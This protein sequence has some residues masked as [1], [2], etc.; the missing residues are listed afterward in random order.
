M[1]QSPSQRILVVEDEPKMLSMITQFLE[2]EGW[3]VYGSATGEEA[4]KLMPKVAPDVV[5]LDWMLPGMSGLDVCRRIRAESQVPLIMLTAKADEVDKL[6]GLE[7]GADDYITK[8]FS[9]RELLARI[10]AVLRRSSAAWREER[11]GIGD[12]II[13][14]DK[15]EVRKAGVKVQ[16]TPTEFKILSILAS[17]PGRVYS[18]LQLVDA[19]LGQ[20]Y[21]GYERSIDTHISNLRKK[22]GDDSAQPRYIDT[23][24]GVGYKMLDARGGD[25]DDS[26]ER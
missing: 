25:A 14:L 18:R 1:Q 6:L 8:P 3:E 4:L 7:L 16:L 20:A 24:Y 2:G 15:H 17:S 21:Q 11:L 23:V 22:L 10:R 13:D 9:L 19:V 5:V 12:L 26:L